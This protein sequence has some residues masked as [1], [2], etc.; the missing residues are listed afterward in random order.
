[1]TA[2]SV[3]LDASVLIRAGVER[4]PRAREWLRAVEAA[5]VEGHVPDVA[6]AETVSGLAKYVRA[7][8]MPATL[9][10]RI[11]DEIVALPLFTHGHAR[12]APASLSLALVHGLSAYDASYLALARSLDVPL[13]TADRRL[14]DVSPGSEL[15]P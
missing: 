8:L 6:Y 10:A 3:V 1:M 7:K 13:I 5:E 14:A 2:D 4:E 11:V 9:A 12:L 15:L